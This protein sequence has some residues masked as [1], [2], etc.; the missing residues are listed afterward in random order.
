MIPFVCHGCG[1]KLNAPDTRAG[2]HCHCPGCRALVRIPRE[3]VPREPVTIAPKSSPRVPTPAPKGR[4]EK[5]AAKTDDGI[6]KEI[7][8]GSGEMRTSQTAEVRAG[9]VPGYEL[10]EEIGRGGMGVIFKARQLQPRRLVA[11]KMI[12]AGEYAGAETVARFKAEAEAVARLSHPN[13]VQIYQVG[14]QAGRPFLTLEFIEGGSLSDYLRKHTL[15]FKQAAELI[16]QLALAV[17][18]AHR[19]GI[20]HRDI[21]PGNVLLA[22]ALERGKK[23]QP[24][25]K[26]TDFGLA[27]SLEGA[28]S[29]EPGVKTQSGAILGTPGYIAPEQAGGKSKDV[30]WAADVYSLG[31]ILY[32]CLTG[33]PPFEA[34]TVLDTIMK[35]LNEEPVPPSQRR[36]RCPRDLEIICLKC[37]QKDP[38][39]RYATAGELAE[40]LQRYLEGEAIRA[41]PPGRLAALRRMLRRRKEFLYY[42]AGL[43]TATV[44]FLGWTYFTEL[45]HKGPK[46]PVGVSTPAGE[47]EGRTPQEG[48]RS[49]SK[50]PDTEPSPKKEVPR[51]LGDDPADKLASELLEASEATRPAVLRKLRD[52]KQR[53]CTDAL[54]LAINR[55][56]GDAQAQARDALANRL[57]GTTTK[58]LEAYLEDGEPEVRRAAARACA[59]KKLESS[60]PALIRLLGDPQPGVVEAAHVAL[61]SLAGEDVGTTPEAWQE[62][63]K[64][65]GP[66]R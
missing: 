54:A 59:M 20:L 47:P 57:A 65:R 60:I 28:T 1:M 46:V 25:P 31:A 53:E 5:P 16:R 38:K 32:E 14:E 49:S 62:W 44:I 37:L 7:T 4:Q 56:D 58:A 12:L 52:G 51:P 6:S 41:R 26:I 2:Q 23:N 24:V 50:K 55:L 63:Q 3:P 15:R 9:G 66:K 42:V 19:R 34:S 30:G 35:A 29:L 64:T 21:K 10:L 45:R 27:K 43:L 61:V 13:I 33:R 22:P 48:P 8:A 36:W 18:Y 40:D 39:N 17:D 11:L